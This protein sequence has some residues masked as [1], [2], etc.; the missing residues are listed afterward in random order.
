[1]TDG[2]RRRTEH[3]FEAENL[4]DGARRRPAAGDLQEDGLGL[5]EHGVDVDGA[6]H[7]VDV[8]EDFRESKFIFD[9]N[10][11]LGVEES[12]ANE[13]VE[14]AARM[15]RPQHLPQTHDVGE[16]ELPLEMN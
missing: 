16:G 7:V 3:G 5:G 10:V 9:Q 13:Q 1:M 8:F 6:G 14:I 2:R 4:G 12:D 15:T 11:F